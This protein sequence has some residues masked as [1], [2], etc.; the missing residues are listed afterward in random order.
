MQKYSSMLSSHLYPCFILL[1]RH[2]QLILTH[3]QRNL[4]PPP[5]P[6]LLPINNFTNLQLTRRR[7]QCS[8]RRYPLHQNLCFRNVDGRH[9][10]SRRF[11]EQI[12]EGNIQLSRC[13]TISNSERGEDEFRCEGEFFESCLDWVGHEVIED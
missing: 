12:T 7:L 4:P 10:Y 6:L 2:R 11:L 3:L 1:K 9:T 13:S 5:S 8:G